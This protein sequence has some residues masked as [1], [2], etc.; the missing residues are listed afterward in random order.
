MPSNGVIMKLRNS[1]KGALLAA[2]LLGLTACGG[3]EPIDPAVFDAEVQR[4]AD[5]GDMYGEIFL[6]LKDSRPAL[7]N[8]FRTIAVREFGRG[9]PTREASYVA[10][11]QM[12]EK[13]LSEILQLSRVASDEHAKQIIDVTMATLT[14]LNEENTADCVRSI[15]GLPPEKVD[16]YPPELRKQEMQLITDLLGAPKTTAQRRAA[17]EKEVLNWMVNLASTDEDISEMFRLME[18]QKRTGKQNKAVCEGM[19]TVY[20]R[21]SYKTA[22]KRGTLFRGMALI[23]LR[24]QQLQRLE[25][26]EDDVAT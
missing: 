14:H 5:E 11:M 25:N 12:R 17:S 7:Y 3:S 10:G 18:V 4:L 8:E 13:F 22:E 24:Q 19:I 15:E 1:F 21:L 9:R 2:S 20:K 16:K 6:V 23:A 26:A